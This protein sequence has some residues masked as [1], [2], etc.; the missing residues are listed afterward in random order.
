MSS[1]CSTNTASTSSVSTSTDKAKGAGCIDKFVPQ[2]QPVTVM[3]GEKFSSANELL[4][5]ALTCNLLPSALLDS[6]EF[7][8]YLFIYSEEKVAHLT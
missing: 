8:I 1:S 2:V 5:K 3:K 7:R 4:V 6:P